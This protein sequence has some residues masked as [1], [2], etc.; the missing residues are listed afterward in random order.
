[1]DRPKQL[2]SHQQLTIV[3]LTENSKF[4]V[5]PSLMNSHKKS[6]ILALIT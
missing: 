4:L 5:R 1:M 3:A 2:T 6:Q